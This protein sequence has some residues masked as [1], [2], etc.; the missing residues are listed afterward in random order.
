MSNIPDTLNGLRWKE[1][2]TAFPEI[3]DLADAR[4]VFWGRS[5]S[6]TASS[7]IVSSGFTLQDV[8]DVALRLKRFSP[9]MTQIFPE[10]SARGGVME[11]P[12]RES[13][14]VLNDLKKYR[15]LPPVRL[16]FK[17]DNMLPLSASLKDRGGVYEVLKLAEDI[18][19]YAK[20][21]KWSDNYAKLNSLGMRNFFSKFSLSVSSV[22]NLGLAAGLMGKALGFS[23]SAHT[24]KE[25]RAWKKDYMRSKGI[26]VID[27]NVDC[28]EVLKKARE[29]AAAD[30]ACFFVGEENSRNVFLGYT[31]AGM[32][33]KSNLCRLGIEIDG[34]RPLHVYIPCGSGLAASGLCL[35]LKLAFM[36]NVRCFLAE[37]VQA[38]S[39]LLGLGTRLFDKVSVRDIGLSGLTVADELSL[40]RPSSLACAVLR[41]MADG[42]VTVEDDE[43]FKLLT[44]VN[45]HERSKLEPSALAGLAAFM[46]TARNT[47]GAGFTQGV[48]LVW[49]SGG[50]LTPDNEWRSYY[51]RGQGML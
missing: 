48:H 15:P 42:C 4:P 28:A 23:V 32:N 35:G 50:G 22:G 12:L 49:L 17:M 44:I 27:Y 33:I 9:F 6:L 26:E 7:A 41:E 29:E 39:M 40:C 25:T 37:P 34:S 21:L 13:Q 19:I 18:G 47:L 3:G 2:L 46:L 11:S 31:T 36:D 14:A 20:K 8:K 43:L 30:P 5:Q 10:T 38:P 45:T 51:E 24:S 1:W 16:F